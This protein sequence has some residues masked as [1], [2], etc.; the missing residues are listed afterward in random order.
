M[1]P[2]RKRLCSGPQRLHE[3]CHP[4]SK[5]P[6][7][8]LGRGT[9][10]IQETALGGLVCRSTPQP[11]LHW[12]PLEEEAVL[13]KGEGMKTSH[14]EAQEKGFRCLIPGLLVSPVRS[15]M[16]LKAELILDQSG[17]ARKTAE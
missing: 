7:P 17:A 3:P 15:H 11:G 12:G 10:E 14:E 5:E 13:E 9:L 4:C 2:S 16:Y 1:E 8:G 6:P